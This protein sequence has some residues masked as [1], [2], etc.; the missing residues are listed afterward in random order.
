M[1]KIKAINEDQAVCDL[2]GKENLK[3]VVWLENEE[4]EVIATGTVCASKLLKIPVKAQKKNE[5]DFVHAQKWAV[6]RD[7][8]LFWATLPETPEALLK[9]QQ[10]AYKELDAL[11]L[12]FTKRKEWIA[13]DH[14]IQAL[15]DW[16]A[17]R[18]KTAEDKRHELNKKYGI[19][20]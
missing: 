18:H 16:Y 6:K 1:W 7:F 17:N 2:C 8:D 14:R 4:G 12:S 9:N 11:K 15:A 20:H 3:R 19:A 10:E 13:T 5:S